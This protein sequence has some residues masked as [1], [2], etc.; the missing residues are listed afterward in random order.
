[1][2]HSGKVRGGFTLVE[3]LLVVFLMAS[4]AIVALSSYINST[5]TFNFLG[6]YQRVMSTLQTARSFAISNR[7]QSGKTPERYGVCIG[8]DRALTFVD[9]G[10]EGFK[11]DPS[12]TDSAGLENCLIVNDTKPA[13][14]ES[15]A[16]FDTILADKNFKFENYKLVALESDGATAIALPIFIYYESG[17]GDVSIFDSKNGVIKKSEQK[18]ITLTFSEG[19]K[20]TKYLKISQ[21][22]GLAEEVT[23][24]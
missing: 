5:A 18:F 7:Q 17:T 12:T 20:S 1:M 3:I 13:S 21:V 6:G 10:S 23:E 24:L 11:F 19:T 22:S 15:G 14:T 8:V 4:L 2:T 9:V 16:T